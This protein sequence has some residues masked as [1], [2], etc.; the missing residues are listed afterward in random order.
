[1]LRKR[2]REERGLAK[3]GKRAHHVEQREIGQEGQPREPAGCSRF[4][5]SNLVG[6][7]RVRQNVCREGER[8]LARFDSRC[9]ESECV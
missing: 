4:R 7:C 3:E 9:C 1:M 8:D 2:K 5:V 6:V